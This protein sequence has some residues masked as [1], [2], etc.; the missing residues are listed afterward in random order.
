MLTISGVIIMPGSCLIWLGSISM[1][2]APPISAVFII[3]D[4]NIKLPMLVT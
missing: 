3:N 2:V 4:Y 1:T